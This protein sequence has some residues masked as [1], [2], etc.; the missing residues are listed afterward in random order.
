MSNATIRSEAAASNPSPQS[1]NLADRTA[2]RRQ[3]ASSIQSSDSDPTSSSGSSS[4]D[5][6]ESEREDKQHSDQEMNGTEE[7][8]THANASDPSSIPHIAG[9][10]K[11]RIH[12]IRGDSGLLSRLNAFLPKMKDANE[13]LQKQIEAGEAGDL[14]LDNADENA[15]QYIEMDLGLG[16]LEEKRDGDSSSDEESDDEGSNGVTGTGE[17]PQEMNDSDIIGKLMGGKSKKLNT[18]KPSIEEMA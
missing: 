7:S 17:T 2:P 8:T 13:N 6:N 5:D 11:P 15:E 4:E 10:P 12:R 3:R 16:V 9:R 14:V 1:L 18:D